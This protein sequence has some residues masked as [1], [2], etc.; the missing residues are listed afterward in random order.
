MEGE[1]AA[2]IRVFRGCAGRLKVLWEKKTR[3]GSHRPTG[4]G[5]SYR[6]SGIRCEDGISQGMFMNCV[7]RDSVLA[8]CLQC[9]AAL[10]GM[11]CRSLPGLVSRRS[12]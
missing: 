10:L 6:V 11:L 2:L 1:C 9:V 5:L 8:I 4:G 12:S 7:L 3:T